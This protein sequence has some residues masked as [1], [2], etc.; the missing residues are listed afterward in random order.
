MS[1]Q[2]DTE[3]SFPHIH[4]I[5][6]SA[7][8]GKT[9]LLAA[10]YVQFLLS[11]VIDADISSM[12]AITF[13]NEAT[14]QMKT[15]ILTLLKKVAL[16]PDDDDAVFVANLV[17]LPRNELSRAAMEQVDRV[18]EDYSRF[19]VR[20]I[21]SFVN[22]IARTA[23]FELGFSP[24][25]EVEASSEA[26]LKLSLDRMID[27]LPEDKVVTEAFLNFI[28]E[29]LAQKESWHAA[30][31][32]L[33]TISTL[34]SQ[35]AATGK[36]YE[37]VHPDQL[38][39]LV[40]EARKLAKALLEVIEPQKDE[41]NKNA[42]KA[43]K[44]VANGGDNFTSAYLFK[45]SIEEL[46]KKNN[47]GV[48]PEAYKLYESMKEV[49][50]RLLFLRAASALYH[51]KNLLDLF[52]IEIEALKRRNRVIFFEDIN[53]KVRQLIEE[54]N[55]PEIFFRLGERF[56]HYL[57][58]E[59]QDTS[60]IQW[61]NLKPLIENAL[62]Q[63]GSLFVVGDQKQMIY[64]FRGSD[65]RILERVA[66]EF[67]SA[68]DSV[69]L[70]DTVYNWRSRKAIVDFVNEVFSPDNIRNA[71]G[72]KETDVEMLTE[73]Y[74]GGRQEIPEKLG[75]SRDGGLVHIVPVP[76]PHKGKKEEF[77]EKVRER[78]MAI[79]ADVFTRYSAPDVVVLVRKHSEGEVVAG[80][81]MEKN[82]PV[83]SKR[84]VDIRENPVINNIIAFLRF[85]NMPID[86]VSFAATITG[87]GFLKAAGMS[88]SDVF[89]WL[90][91]VHESDVPL[92]RSFRETYPELWEKLIDPF[93]KRAGYL[94]T[95]E[96]TRSILSAWDVLSANEGL[97]GA[98]AHLLKL[99]HGLEERGEGDLASF[100]KLV[101]SGNEEVFSAEFPESFEGIRIMTMHAAKGLEF[102]VVIAPFIGA[103]N[104]SKGRGEPVEYDSGEWLHLLKLS[105]S[106]AKLDTLVGELYRRNRTQSILDELN[107]LYVTATRAKD[108]LHIIV[109]YQQSEKGELRPPISRLLLGD[110]PA[111]RVIGTVS[112]GEKEPAPSQRYLS[113][114]LRPTD[115]WSESFV[116]R[117]IHLAD[118]T[119]GRLQA[120]MR[121]DL[122]HG[123][124][125]RITWLPASEELINQ[126]VR[127]ALKDE[128]IA[129]AWLSFEPEIDDIAEQIT[130]ALM[131]SG[132]I[133]WFTESDDAEVFTEYEIVDAGGRTFRI[134]RLV[135]RE[136]VVEVIEFKTGEEYT[137][138]HLQQLSTY[139]S[140]IR[141]LYPSRKVESYLFYIDESHI[142]KLGDAG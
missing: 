30:N 120:I 50:H 83:I 63:G 24:D 16:T 64:R 122:V 70:F 41:F 98:V 119:H 25:F 88:E 11:S 73:V 127:R 14:A 141:R 85:L 113:W 19:H 29:D 60:L 66:F 61:D 89:R 79:V 35:E 69:E 22:S 36:N 42:V 131:D 107:L 76:G 101:D 48:P 111:E 7:G 56:R 38:S 90:E 137:E 33:E 52:R 118:I 104:S 133:R 59:F 20:T 28:R 128:V 139:H 115:G 1:L 3:L 86:D 58:D 136:A 75:D 140:L 53:L 116:R 105:S 94:P 6:A 126:R 117:E 92:Y 103:S 77:N 13:T 125:A 8:S 4:V 18:I 9:Y 81:L 71:F 78:F 138:E 40:D 47:S 65:P 46:A 12:L 82:I 80:W 23:S 68:S 142:M 39:M 17:N 21:D 121:G 34:L 135:L 10:R 97:D 49:L 74:S 114:E 5:R 44:K 124:L 130:Y 108:E 54:L 102:P 2:K 51:R 27:R 95:Y 15:R 112:A 32:V 134:D 26:Y 67:P 100:L 55:V 93:F 91:S 123:A 96:L 37:F 84:L 110:S 62:S 129:R 99:L 43:L 45:S 72:D 106:Y 57:I 31:S 132:A 87:P 109:A